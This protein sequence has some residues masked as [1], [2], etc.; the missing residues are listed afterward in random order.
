LVSVNLVSAVPAARRN[1][2]RT[3]A[4]IL[5]AALREFS[6]K[7]LAG[8]RVDAIARRAGVNKRMLYHYFG[9]K[10]ALFHAILRR[11]LAQQAR[12]LAT[13]PDDPADS[14]PYWFARA[15]GDPAWI[16]LMEWE[17]LERGA[18]PL[19]GEAERRSAFSHALVRLREHQAEKL[20]DP[21]LDPAQLLLSMIA[22]TTFPLAFPQITRLVTGSAP[23]SPGFRRRRTAFLRLFADRLRPR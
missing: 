18:R 21:D 13:T 3:R 11:K 17:A 8:G 16:R 9:G 4:R 2:A 14:L 19:T 12:W 5:A 1:P 22:L 7:G 10:E 23:T 15:L 20:V 6:G